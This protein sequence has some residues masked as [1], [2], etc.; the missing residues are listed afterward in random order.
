MAFGEASFVQENNVELEYIRDFLMQ[1][2]SFIK[3][4]EELLARI[5]QCPHTG[6]VIS[7]EEIARN[8]MLAETQKA[9]TRFS[10]IVETARKNYES[11]IRVQE[12]IIAVLDARNYDELVETLRGHVCFA[13]AADACE[14]VISQT[15]AYSE[16]MDKK[17]AIVERLVPI[18][19]PVS[20]GTSD[21]PR[22]WLY[23]EKADYIR[24]EALARI[25]FGIGNR[26]GMLA[27][28]SSDINCFRQD[29][30]HELI[31]FFARVV[32]RALGRFADDGEI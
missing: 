30:G 21:S 17:G 18:E 4:D 32:E 9:K 31:T 29:M 26:F 2:P 1:N 24:S 23:N 11:Q 15:A 13:L 22:S 6:N 25:E 28:A 7:L 14:I 12:A 20:I 16:I 5:T 19:R 3:Q 10:Q 8:R 27:I